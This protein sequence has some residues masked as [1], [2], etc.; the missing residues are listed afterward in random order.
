LDEN[1]YKQVQGEQA[2]LAGVFIF[3]TVSLCF[4]VNLLIAQLSCSYSKVF[5]DM[6]GCARLERI[7][8][9]GS[10]LPHVKP[11]VWKRF[12]AHMNLDQRIE[13]NEGD[14]GVSGGIQTLEGANFH[15]TTVDQIKRYGGSTS[16]TIQWPEEDAPL[17]DEA[18]KMERL[19]SLV[20][21]SMDRIKKGGP[22]NRTTSAVPGSLSDN[23]SE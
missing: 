18:E 8:I 15:P 2:I 10:Y 20:R 6:V 21:K 12:I 22:K 14:I 23:S 19:E 17:L 11:R 16:P 1:R 5:A 4:L 3:M 13:F 9:I 7:K